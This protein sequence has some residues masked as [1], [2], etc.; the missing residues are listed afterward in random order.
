MSSNTPY[1]TDWHR[2]QEHGEQALRQMKR[3]I[4][5]KSNY[6]MHCYACNKPIY[7]GD[8]ITHVES[9]NGMELRWR[10]CDHI[11]ETDYGPSFYTPIYG[12][13]LWV[14]RDCIPCFYNKK[15]GEYTHYWTDHSSYL[16]SLYHEHLESFNEYSK[17]NKYDEY[18]MYYISYD[19]WRKNNG[20]EK[21]T[22]MKDMLDKYS[23]RI[24]KA[25]KRHTKKISHST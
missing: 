20:Y 19:N 22:L 13:N 21:A 7:R 24:Q 4:S 17:K 9:S 16:H 25:W 2:T 23:K 15:L 11:P 10:G 1:Y 6:K 12:K 5:C 3:M 8:L 18:E 14:H